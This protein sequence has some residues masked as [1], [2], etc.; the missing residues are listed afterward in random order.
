MQLLCDSNL[1]F[2]SVLT[3]FNVNKIQNRC[4]S[5]P[6]RPCDT[7][8]VQTYLKSWS[9]VRPRDENPPKF[10][11]RSQHGFTRLRRADRLKSRKLASGMLITGLLTSRQ[12]ERGRERERQK[13]TLR[14]TLLSQNEDCP[15]TSCRPQIGFDKT[16]YR[17]LPKI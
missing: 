10:L 14:P 7:R 12:N 8:L 2:C 1:N 15:R 5:V 6:C 13:D 16:N 9:F 17:V 3:A 11:R 4:L